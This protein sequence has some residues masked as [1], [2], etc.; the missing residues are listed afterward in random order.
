MIYKK[1]NKMRMTFIKRI[2]TDLI[3]YDYLNPFK[4]CFSFFLRINL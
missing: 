3:P 2:D 4:Q 1:N